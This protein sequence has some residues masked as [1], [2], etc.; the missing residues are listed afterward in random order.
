[1]DPT[2]SNRIPDF[3]P[4][5]MASN[6]KSTANDGLLPELMTKRR[7]LRKGTTS[8]WEC[9]RR[10]VRCSLVDSPGAA[11]IPCQR[12]GTKCVTQDLPEDLSDGVQPET[13]ATTP[14]TTGSSHRVSPIYTPVTVSITRDT[15]SSPT[16]DSVTVCIVV[17]VDRLS[18]C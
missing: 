15:Q 6:I 16:Q 2:R 9:K 5:S 11:C 4:L 18:R 1:M 17:L 13:L 12:R 8:C 3:C 14:S 10:K 7:K